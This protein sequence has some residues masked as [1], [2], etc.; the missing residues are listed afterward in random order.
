MTQHNKKLLRDIPVPDTY[1]K[2]VDELLEGLPEKTQ[3]GS[4]RFSKR[5]IYRVAVCCV[6]IIA[7]ISLGALGANA[8]LFDDF[9]RT[10]LNYFHISTEDTPGQIGLETKTEEVL[11]KPDLLIELKETVVSSHNIYLLF[12]ITAPPD[13]A[14]EDNISFDYFSFC[15]GESYNTDDMIPGATDCS[16]LEVKADK[17]NQAIYVMEITSDKEIT[18]G[19][20]ITAYFRNLVL[21]PHEDSPKLLVEGIWKLTFTADYTVT[22]EI[23]CT[24]IEDNAIPFVGDTAYVREVHITPLG[25]TVELDVTNI[26]GNVLGVSD[27]TIS[28]RLKLV[29]GSEL[30]IM[31]H[32]TEDEVAVESGSCMYNETDDAAL[33]TYQFEFAEVLAIEKIVGIYVEDIYIPVVDYED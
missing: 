21:N 14:F 8:S 33:Q 2:R 12:Q 28:I 7:V 11:S 3:K 32:N 29:D 23:S 22:D 24:D 17:K 30:L 16:L 4:G 25:M 18:D 6:I 27:T 1:T 19:E 31:S 9:K 5:T 10:L 26:P 13:I 20:P 15:K